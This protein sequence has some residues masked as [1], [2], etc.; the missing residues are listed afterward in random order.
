MTVPPRTGSAMSDNPNDVEW[1]W[2]EAVASNPRAIDR[3]VG[4][5]LRELRLARG[6]S[7]SRVAE[8]VGLSFQQIQKYE[9]GANRITMGR[10]YQLADVLSADVGD[11]LA[12]VA[13]PAKRYSDDRGGATQL[14]RMMSAYSEVED[15]KLRAA[16]LQL[17]VAAA[18][19]DA[20]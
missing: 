1:D 10:L 15:P 8:A 2:E 18:K 5:K 4:A 9:N 16:I 11:I 7:Q 3:R 6:F 20:D 12:A 19:L 17:T 14:T 13:E